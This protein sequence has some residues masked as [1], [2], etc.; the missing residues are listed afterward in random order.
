MLEKAFLLKF[1]N[2]A[3]KI[4]GHIYTLVIVIIGW[5]LFSMEE[6]PG[7]IGYLSS[8]FGGGA[9]L[10]SSDFLYYLK[11]Y[12]ITLLI[13]TAASTPLPIML[14]RRLP[15]KL[16]NITTPVIIVLILI[17]STAYLVDSTYNPFMYFRF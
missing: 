9:G 16:T 3:P 12:G 4:A 1:F 13:L 11:D 8:M 10:I 17:L 2:K 6:L 5:V 14:Y 15:K 7:T